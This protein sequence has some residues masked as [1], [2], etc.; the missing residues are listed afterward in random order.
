MI[1][2]WKAMRIL[3][4]AVM[5]HVACSSRYAVNSAGKVRS[6]GETIGTA[7]ESVEHQGMETTQWQ[8]FN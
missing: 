3:S 1:P 8:G 5:H 4:Y 2:Y 6:T 7:L